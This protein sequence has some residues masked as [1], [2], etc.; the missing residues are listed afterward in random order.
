[1]GVLNE[2]NKIEGSTFSAFLTLLHPGMIAQET[3][4]S[5]N[6]SQ[7]M[8]DHEFAH[9][10]MQAVC[11]HSRISP[12][13]LTYKGG[14]THFGFVAIIK[15][16]GDTI[17]FG[18]DR[19]YHEANNGESLEPIFEPEYPTYIQIGNEDNEGG[20]RKKSKSKVNAEDAISGESDAKDKG[21][22]KSGEN[23]KS[24]QSAGGHDLSSRKRPDGKSAAET[25]EGRTPNRGRRTKEKG[26]APEPKF[27]KVG[28]AKLETRTVNGPIGTRHR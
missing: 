22:R 15:S 25:A 1:M 13:E 5:Q 8:V 17:I 28:W 6:P 19:R 4:H 16:F 20:T 23:S 21:A 12:L 9:N 27:E 18:K 3:L 14:Q 7:G 10:I 26:S 2:M 24:K 11:D